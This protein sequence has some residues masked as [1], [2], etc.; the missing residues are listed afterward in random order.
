M[1]RRDG[2]VDEWDETCAEV[3]AALLPALAIV[4]AARRPRDA[5]KP[6]AAARVVVFASDTMGM[7]MLKRRE[8]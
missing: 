2:N 1:Q 4:F 7:F 3:P 5:A 8:I 6:R